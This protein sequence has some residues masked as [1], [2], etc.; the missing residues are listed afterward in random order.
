MIARKLAC[1]AVAAATAFQFG[2]RGGGDESTAG[3]IQVALQTDWFPQAEHGG[4]YQ[5]LALGYYR[6]A[7]LEVEILSGGPNSMALQKVARGDAQFANW[8]SDEAAAGV[9]R[10]LPIRLVGAYLQKDPQAIMMR[11]GSAVRSFEDLDGRTLMAAPG[12]AW[13]AYL[14]KTRGIQPRVVPLSYGLQQFLADPELVQQCF[15][16]S[17]PFHARQQ[18]VAVRTMLIAD[19]GYDSF[20]SLVGNQAFLQA[21]PQAAAAFVEASLRGWR[22]FI[23][24]DPEPAIALILERNARMTREQAVYSR[25]AMIDQGLALGDP[26]VGQALGRLDMQRISRQLATLESIGLIEPGV[27][28]EQ[29]ATTEFLPDWAR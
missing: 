11:E 21:Q 20:R 9:T 19:S 10:G 29:V 1:L 7:G 13:L 2:C 3:P 27:A 16:T 17:E 26:A 6:E 15:V 28:A 5:A 14:Q 25:Q 4:F 8:R 12:A 23:H 18:G 22:E 24:G